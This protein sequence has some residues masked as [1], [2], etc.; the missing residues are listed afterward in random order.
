MTL[1]DESQLA[2]P[3]AAFLRH[4]PQRVEVIGRRL[5][6]FLQSGWDIN[7]LARI[8][9]EA[10]SLGQVSTRLG[11]HAPGQHLLALRDLLTQPV[12]DEALPDPTLGERL[13]SVLESLRGTVPRGPERREAPRQAVNTTTR[14]EPRPPA[15]W[16]RWGED[17]PAPTYPQAYLEPEPLAPIVIP[18][19]T[20]VIE[21]APPDLPDDIDIWGIEP[22]VRV[23]SRESVGASKP[24]V[25]EPAP[26]DIF[27]REPA[28]E[29]AP[30]P[31]LQAVEPVAP[32]AAA[33]GPDA[34]RLNVGAGYRIYHLTRYGPI[35]L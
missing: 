23:A 30:P 19:E 35:S 24:P 20:A 9:R 2:E 10:G 32:A 13:C 29:R 17:A 3:Q 33:T 22:V 27:E 7:G 11:L 8:H 4:L 25:L 28:A 15:Y 1:P 6:R 18:L 34:Y 12:Q 26:V 14:A 5:Q 16:R 31:R 21:Q